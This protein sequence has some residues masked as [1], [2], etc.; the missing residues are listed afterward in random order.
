MHATSHSTCCHAEQAARDKQFNSLTDAAGELMSLGFEDIYSDSKADIASNLHSDADQGVSKGGAVWHDDGTV[1]D[2]KEHTMYQRPESNSALSYQEAAQAVSTDHQ[3][4]AVE[5]PQIPTPAS[6]AISA[7]DAAS[8]DAAATEG[9]PAD[10]PSTTLEVGGAEIPAALAPSIHPGNGA[11]AQ[12]SARPVADGP[13]ADGPV[14]SQ[15][16]DVLSVGTTAVSQEP[17]PAASNSTQLPS[18]HAKAAAAASYITEAA[19][20]HAAAPDDSASH[21]D[22]KAADPEAQP[23]STDDNQAVPGSAHKAVAP[24]MDTHM[25][26]GRTDTDTALHAAAASVQPQ[27][28]TASVTAPTAQPETLRRG[29]AKGPGLGESREFTG[30]PMN[31]ERPKYRH[32]PYG[33]PP[34]RAGGRFSPAGGR[35]SPGGRDS[36]TGRSVGRGF[37]EPPR[38]SIMRPQYRQQPPQHMPPGRCPPPY[39]AGYAPQPPPPAPHHAHYYPPP[40][41]QAYAPAPQQGYS[42]QAYQPPPQQAYPPQQYAQPAQYDAQWQQYQETQGQYA[43]YQ[44]PTAYPPPAAAPPPG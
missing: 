44:Q 35:G 23:A 34:I 37:S 4:T 38:A 1:K 33:P 41:Q 6:A 17:I 40:P 21:P 10:V 24:G 36:P 25:A 32:T 12:E 7:S 13:V 15:Q 16:G 26:D 39:H 18:P 5:T 42:Q 31:F 8:L 11:V 29:P 14:D 9:T 20:S 30:G 19:E 43:A 27:P 28:E 22:V 3:P 2:A